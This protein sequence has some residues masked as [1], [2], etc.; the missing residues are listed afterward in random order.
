MT[1]SLT[2]KYVDSRLCMFRYAAFVPHGTTHVPFNTAGAPKDELSGSELSKHPEVFQVNSLVMT[3]LY[4]D[5]R[6]SCWRTRM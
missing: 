5:L 2:A 4:P 3:L 1:M 6:S